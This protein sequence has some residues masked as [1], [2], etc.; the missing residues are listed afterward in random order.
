MAHVT[1]TVGQRK[2]VT[3]VT[4]FPARSR[5]DQTAL[6]RAKYAKFPWMKSHDFWWLEPEW[7]WLEL[8]WVQIP[9]SYCAWFGRYGSLKFYVS[10]YDTKASL[11]GNRICIILI[12][13]WETDLSPWRKPL[14]KSLAIERPPGV[15]FVCNSCMYLIWR[16]WPEKFNT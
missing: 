3:A 12:R 4:F 14:Y 10:C 1:F 16:S 15:C 5:P 7:M 6:I 11:P 2:K 9:A 8:S 13:R